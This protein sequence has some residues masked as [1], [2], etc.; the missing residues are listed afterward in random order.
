MVSGDPMTGSD[1]QILIHRS[2]GQDDLHFEVRAQDPA[3][4]IEFAKFGPV[5]VTADLK[6]V[7]EIFSQ[8]F[9]NRPVR[10][11][12]D[13]AVTPDKLDAI[14]TV[15]FRM[16]PKGLRDLLRFVQGKISNLQIVSDESNIPWEI[17]KLPQS[18]HPEGGESAG[19]FL[20]EAFAV[21]R[22]L[23]GEPQTL[24][25]PLRSTALVFSRSSNLPVA[26]VERSAVFDFAGP[27]HR[28]VEIEA[29]LAG[30]MKAL[31]SGE[32]DGW[33]FR[34]H[35]TASA[36]ESDRICLDLED[37]QPFTPKHLKAVGRSFGRKRP[38][39]FINACATGGGDMLSSEFGGW[40]QRF[41][42][43]GAGAFLGT[44]WPIEDS[45]ARE[46]ARLF[47]ENFLSGAPIGEAVRRARLGLRARYPSSP[48]WLA[49]TVFAHPLAMCPS[50]DIEPAFPGA[51]GSRST[52]RTRP[53]L[54]Q[55]P[56][57]VF[58]QPIWHP[59]VSPPG[60]LLRAEYQVVPFHGREREMSD[61]FSWCM[62]E[63]PVRVRLYTGPGGMGKTRLVLELA[64]QMRHEG[65]R[66]GF[67]EATI[68][69]EEIGRML[70]PPAGRL[71]LVVDYAETRRDLLI[72]LLRNLYQIERGPV[73]LILLAR[74][75]LDWWE[76]LKVERQGIGE[77]LSGPATS[78]HSIAPLALSTE[79]RAEA[80]RTAA[81][82]FA[83]R[84]ELPSP[85]QVP[86]DLDANYFERIMLLHMAALM[87]V[88]GGSFQ[89]EDEVLDFILQAE[90]KHW[91]KLAQ[92]RGIPS[93]GI[94]GI[95]RAMAAVT[96]GGGIDSEQHALEALRALHSLS[97]M[98]ED[99]LIRIARLLHEAYAGKRWIEPIQPDLLGEHLV[100][101]EMEAGGT[102]ELLD[103]VL[104]P[105]L[106]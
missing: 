59:E 17:V 65:W 41:L 42:R 7:L 70:D 39:V 47:Y 95:S 33:Y 85:A 18:D 69:S 58:P 52:A 74:A 6:T 30:L 72:P 105:V 22:W 93:D 5:R 55:N 94:S 24:E 91:R 13:L 84:L 71:L 12:E 75:A 46:F 21:T 97:S 1:L 92:V 67:L 10:T 101:R 83:E 63:A 38:L 49:Y 14:G 36:S 44:L 81:W 43:A 106:S 29:K 35:T 86:K 96:L 99:V 32:F 26:P 76:Q 82:A 53:R 34:G 20:C 11:E 3:L 100:Q 27:E 19:A 16:L 78:R 60:A 9:P 54:F 56:L 64:S 79:Q 4:G 62:D 28:V 23:H 80:F 77:L 40:A 37:E 73:R 87:T 103:L 61:L 104:G 51:V 45:P 90:R 15:L 8:Y 50:A 88:E 102:D 48:T 2:P 31:G 57:L 25:L 98:S 68:S 66:A 89:Q